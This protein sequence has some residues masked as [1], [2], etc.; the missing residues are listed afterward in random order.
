MFKV[1]DSVV[2]AVACAAFGLAG[3]SGD[4]SEPVGKGQAESSL[5]LNIQVTGADN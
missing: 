4:D 2:A 3:C 5:P 1:I